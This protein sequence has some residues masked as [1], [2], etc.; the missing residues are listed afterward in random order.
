MKTLN[1]LKSA[2][3]NCRNFSILLTLVATLFA[4]HELKAQC[5]NNNAFYTSISSLNPGQTH[6][7][8][9][10]WGGEYVTIPVVSG[11]QY[12]ISTCGGGSWDTQLTIYNNT[13]GSALGYNDDACGLQSTIVW[14]ANFTGT[15][16]ILLDQFSCQSNSSCMNITVS[17]ANSAVSFNPCSSV[18]SLN[19]SASSNA[20]I[21]S[22]NGIWNN[23]GGPYTTPGRER[24]FSFTPV[25]S[26]VH[27][28]TVNH[29]SSGWIDLFYKAANI[30]CNAS[31]WTYV[32][33]IS[34][35]ETWAVTL[36]AGV[37]YYIM[38]DDEDINGSNASLSISC[39]VPTLPCIGPS[40]GIDF[41]F[42]APF[43]H[44]SSTSGACNDC[45]LNS[46][47]D[48]VYQINISCPGTYVFS[49][50][51]GASWDTYLYLGTQP[52]GG[53]I[54]SNDDACGLQSSITA[55]LNIGIY[56]LVVEGFS[57][58][59]AGAYVLNVTGG[60][61]P[62]TGNAVISGASN[63]CQ[64]SAQSYNVSGV[65]GATSYNWVVN[66]G[67]I[68]SGQG[69]SNITVQWN[70]SNGAVSVVPVSACGNGAQ[71]NLNVTVNQIPL[72]TANV[73]N[74]NCNGNN[75]GSI[76]ILPANA[77]WQYSINGGQ[78]Y[79]GINTFSN[80]SPGSYIVT[81][82]VA[83]LVG[84][85]SQAV[86][87]NI[88]QPSVLIGNISVSNYNGF[89]VSCNG[90][91]NGSAAAQ[92]NGGTAPYTYAWSNNTNNQTA[93]NLAAGNYNVSITDANGCAAS[94]SAVLTEPQALNTSI[95]TSNFNGFNISCFG[96]NNGSA[97]A[98]VTGG[99]APYSYAWSNST[100]NQTASNL[101]AGNYNVSITDANG[102][103]N[104]GSAVMTEPQALN[105]SIATSD[106]NG[107]NI[108][109]F[110]G[111]NGSATANATGGLAPYSYAWSNNTNNQTASN[112]TAGNY[113]VSITDA[114]GCTNSGSAV[115]TQPQALNT[116]ITTSNFNGFNIS[117]FGGN[118]G[119]AT[120]NVTGGV[121][122]YS[123][124]WSNSTNAQTAS[125]L[126][127][128]NYNVTITDANGCITNSN[129]PLTEPSQLL[130]STGPNQI[131]YYGYTPASCAT[132][133][134]AGS[135]G[136]PS[137]N[138]SWSGGGNQA[139]T[140]V[141]PSVTTV[142]TVTVTD[143]NGC[144][145]TGIV[146]VCA[147]NVIC[148]A[149]NSNVA[150]VQVCHIPPGNNQNPQ[151]ICINA[152]A[153]PAH[154]AQGAYLGSCGSNTNTCS[155]TQS[156]SGIGSSENNTEKTP[157]II[158][159]HLY[160][161]PASDLISVEFFTLEKGK[162][163]FEI[164]DVT[165]RMML[166]SEEESSDAYQMQ[167]TQISVKELPAGVYFLNITHNS[168]QTVKK[169]VVEK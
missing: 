22:G 111:N 120:A 169:F 2:A 18:T 107:F 118:N 130:V 48:R 86:S 66:G 139:N 94:A 141:C 30:G 39:P 162:T 95:A 163:S 91:N 12:N 160:P 134:S 159:L 76:Q 150:K 109:C 43:N 74:V 59:S 168:R 34:G 73:T 135:G 77:G 93:S 122:P 27:N 78:S 11:S 14:T 21:S 98:N 115:M 28:I 65:S 145:E 92:A 57:S 85:N 149:G 99:V 137:Y 19:C 112:L 80:L 108:S 68:I 33:D 136:V 79:S 104:S 88:S 25:T 138:Y 133:T 7:F 129:I 89:G 37:T 90:G 47:P 23:Y 49:L 54:A 62:V 125:G 166:K 24:I 113:N 17:R 97:T 44:S 116:S 83:N 102:C 128:G 31:G 156:R 84:C 35:T 106:F 96:G 46:S 69:S 148:F 10:V 119:S 131:V 167:N 38:L 117:C 45:S 4:G 70:S 51:N 32:N 63:V 9:C 124:A 155:F 58:S 143:A 40:N 60:G 41:T 82:R 6:V 8:S 42:T 67:S 114:N 153:V 152:N 100:N 13:G 110:G 142:Y 146:Q 164:K 121:T 36:T 20:N 61:T 127:A 75:N 56:Y 72:I 161:N 101:T 15:L 81:A 3:E 144:T 29:S 16:R 26:G 154:L 158:D 53:V 55:N 151:T 1:I 140:T 165:G 50:C 132:I 5:A 87:V 157:H 71:A 126:S 105:T 64:G 103:T 147:V 123:Y 52:C